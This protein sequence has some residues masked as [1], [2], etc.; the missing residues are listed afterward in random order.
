[1]KLVFKENPKFTPSN[2]I[3]GKLIPLNSNLDS[4]E[5]NIEIIKIRPDYYAIH[6]VNT[7]LYIE[8][9]NP[10]FTEAIDFELT[11]KEVH[12]KL[13]SMIIFNRLSANY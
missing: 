9:E 2:L 3:D 11:D 10:L 12:D 7:G 8:P 13:V 1:M 5:N 6:L 4:Y